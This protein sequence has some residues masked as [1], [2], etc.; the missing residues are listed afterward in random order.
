[1]YATWKKRKRK[2]NTYNKKRHAGVTAAT[3]TVDRVVTAVQAFAGI[4]TVKA[5]KQV[6]ITAR[7]GWKSGLHGRPTLDDAHIVHD[8][9]T[10]WPGGRERDGW[11]PRGV[12]S[13]GVGV[14]Y[15]TSISM[16]IS[17]ARP[18]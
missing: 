15:S 9:L 1:M 13:D 4:V 16:Q 18:R 11:R 17:R 2:K 10:P 7:E 14:E 12:A 3:V 5:L 6:E 8:L